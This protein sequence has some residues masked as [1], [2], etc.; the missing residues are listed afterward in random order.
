MNK[1]E[2]LT[3]GSE[4]H[5]EFLE[6][7]ARY[8]RLG[9]ADEDFDRCFSAV[10]RS[11]SRIRRMSSCVFR[12]LRY[13]FY[14]VVAIALVNFV[15]S[16]HNPT[17]RFCSQYVQDWIYPLMRFVRLSTLP[18]VKHVDIRYLYT[19]SCLLRNPFYAEPDI[20]C[21]PCEGIRF[22]VDLTRTSN[23]TDA[24]YQ[25]GT[26][27]V[28]RDAS[29]D[30]VK[31]ERLCKLFSEHKTIL[32]QGTYAF[33][34]SNATSRTLPAFF[35]STC[36]GAS[37]ANSTLRASWEIDGASAVRILRQLFAR[38][39][40][41]PRES[42]VSLQRY[43]FFDSTFAPPYEL[44]VTDYAN[45]WLMQTSGHRLVVLMPSHQCKQNCHA[46]SVL[47]QA[48]DALYYNL[49]YWRPWS[50]SVNTSEDLSIALMGSSY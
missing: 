42:E 45:V 2:A 10:F 43:F 3:V 31:F 9:V 18:L 29:N 21:W 17:K 49:Q 24:Y 12:S 26:P 34:S 4:I 20:E 25:S 41:I 47:L 6:I 37:L 7:E 11:E 19:T 1:I 28:V 48:K 30:S 27:F 40:F 13:A 14:L 39:Y 46:I 22:V 23:F 36:D 32:R 44:P 33:R 16:N 38:P 15:V 5:R 35:D 8:R 50:Y